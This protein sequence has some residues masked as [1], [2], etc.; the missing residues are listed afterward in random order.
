[1]FDGLAVM[2]T[3]SGEGD[4]VR[5]SAYDGTD[6]TGTLL[7]CVEAWYNQENKDTKRTGVVMLNPGLTATVG[8]YVL[9]YT[10]TNGGSPTYK[11]SA[12]WH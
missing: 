9:V 2:L 6:S 3:S 10:E 4:L 11:A 12:F 5:I 1:M 7:A 8:L